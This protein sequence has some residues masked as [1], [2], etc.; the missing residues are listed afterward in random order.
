MD[1]GGARGEVDASPMLPVQYAHSRRADIK[2]PAEKAVQPEHT[3]V[4]AKEG[5]RNR[6]TMRG[7][8]VQPHRRRQRGGH[9][10]G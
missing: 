1:S 9:R 7:G 6:E 3:D 4:V 10:G 8:D 2:T 5:R